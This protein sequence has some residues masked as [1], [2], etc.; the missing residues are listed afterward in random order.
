[1]NKQPRFK[2]KSNVCRRVRTAPI[3]KAISSPSTRPYPE[4]PEIQIQGRFLDNPP[5]GEFLVR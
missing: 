1:M 4:Y 3:G 5:K 2:R